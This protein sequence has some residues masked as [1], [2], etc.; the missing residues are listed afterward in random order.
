MDPGRQNSNIRL[1]GLRLNGPQ[2][3]HLVT[4]VSGMMNL[5]KQT[6]LRLLNYNDRPNRIYTQDIDNFMQ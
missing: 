4:G 3:D 5:R 6:R 2:G 1:A